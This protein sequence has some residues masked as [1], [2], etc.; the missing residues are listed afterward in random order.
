MSRVAEYLICYDT[1]QIHS[2]VT[3]VKPKAY[4]RVVT[5]LFVFRR[6]VLHDK[7]HEIIP[8]NL[9]VIFSQPQ[10]A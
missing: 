10:N 6:E 2:L 4:I 9:L 8:A 3:V 1:V 7:V 5:D